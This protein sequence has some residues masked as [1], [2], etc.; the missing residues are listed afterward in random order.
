MSEADLW[1]VVDAFQAERAKL[2]GG[3]DFSP[4][5]LATA[6]ETFKGLSQEQTALILA[7]AMGGAATAPGMW[8]DYLA[9][10]DVPGDGSVH[11]IPLQG[12]SSSFGRADLF[13]PAPGGIALTQ[14]AF[15]HLTCQAV[16]S[17]ASVGSRFL[18]FQIDKTSEGSGL[19]YRGQTAFVD[20]Y[21]TAVYDAVLGAGHVIRPAAQMETADTVDNTGYL[22][23]QATA[24]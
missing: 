12:A 5:A 7:A 1:A 16:I 19:L 8:F 10:T 18:G 9:A 11:V 4:Q 3:Q 13:A 15:V 20:G 21:A 22:T 24:V 6:L 14:Q 23:V 2:F 17:S